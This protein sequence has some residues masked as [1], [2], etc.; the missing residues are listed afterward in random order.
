MD[1]DERILS[2]TQGKLSP[3]ALAE[4]E[5]ELVSDARLR[6]ELAALHSAAHHL[7]AALPPV[8]EYEAGWRRLSQEIETK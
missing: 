7:G 2:Y 5:A 4:F 1:R 8:E 3:E 6:A